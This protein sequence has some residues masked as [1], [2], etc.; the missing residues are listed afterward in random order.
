MITWCPS[1][2]LRDGG[3]KRTEVEQ[4]WHQGTFL[5]GQPDGEMLKRT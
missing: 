5:C 1:R 4:C 3:Q 2:R